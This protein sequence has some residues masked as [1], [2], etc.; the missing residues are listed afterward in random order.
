MPYPFFCLAIWRARIANRKHSSIMYIYIYIYIHIINSDMNPQTVPRR[1]HHF[2]DK[3]N[4]YPWCHYRRRGCSSSVQQNPGEGVYNRIRVQ[5]CEAHP[6]DKEEEGS[7]QRPDRRLQYGPSKS[8]L[9]GLRQ[10]GVG[11][12]NR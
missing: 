8:G 10:S 11:V 1:L 2:E 7:T 12:E 6:K 3:L 5:D 9:E 4:H